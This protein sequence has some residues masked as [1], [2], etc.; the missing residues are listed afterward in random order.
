MPVIFAE[1]FMGE[2]RG[3]GKSQRLVVKCMAKFFS[4]VFLA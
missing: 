2:I 4:S 3:D 1:G